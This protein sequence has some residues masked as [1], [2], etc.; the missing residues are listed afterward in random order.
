MIGDAP[1]FCLTF[2]TMSEI[3]TAGLHLGRHLAGRPIG[4]AML[5]LNNAT[6]PGTVLA[7]T[8]T[9]AYLAAHACFARRIGDLDAFLLALDQDAPYEQP[10]LSMVPSA[11]SALYLRGPD[12]RGLVRARAAAMR[13]GSIATCSTSI[14]DRA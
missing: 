3:R 8:G 10:E 13:G 2:V 1:F 6:R 12:R 7:R 9:A 4:Q 11:L 14:P 5:A